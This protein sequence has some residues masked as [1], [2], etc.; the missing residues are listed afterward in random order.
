MGMTAATKLRSIV[1]LAEHA[2]A[3]ELITAAEG[4]DY[5][6]PLVP[7]RGVNQAYEIV[8]GHVRRLTDDRSM[9]EDIEKLVATIQAG[10]FDFLL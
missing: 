6:A 9:S 1:D 2:T 8:R 7:G 10:E 5:R 3:I 4:I